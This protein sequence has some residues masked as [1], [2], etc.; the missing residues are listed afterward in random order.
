MTEQGK[1]KVQAYN[2]SLKSRALS[3]LIYLIDRSNKE[4][5][6]FP[7]V[8]TISDQ[9]HISISTVKRAIRE[10]LQAGYIKRD[11]RYRQNKG[12]TSN[13]YTLVL[14]DVDNISGQPEEVED[15]NTIENNDKEHVYITFEALADA[16]QATHAAALNEQDNDNVE[17]QT[18][19]NEVISNHSTSENLDSRCGILN[20]IHNF[21]VYYVPYQTEYFP[22][23][24]FC[25]HW[26][27]EG[28]KFIPP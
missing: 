27:G 21:I 15:K 14:L 4:L 26:S 28:V 2:S 18:K 25:V 9:L 24:S 8:S 17:Q 22:E 5:N 6:C 16:K 3:V 11:A 7:S 12:Q 23:I 19:Y 1:L 20:K 10:L 13:L